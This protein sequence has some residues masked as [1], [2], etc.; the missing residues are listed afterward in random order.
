[1]KHIILF[2]SASLLSTPYLHVHF[3]AT[4]AC[5]APQNT[6]TIRGYDFAGGQPKVVALPGALGEISGLSLTSGGRLFCHND[7]AGTIYEIDYKTGKEIK[8]FSLGMFTL[9]G[10]FEGIAAAKQDTLF[11]VNSSGVLH[12]F[13]EGPAGKSVKYDV[14][15]TSLTVKNDVEGLAYD[16]KTDCLLLACKGD[17]GKGLGKDKAIYAFSLKTYKLDPKPRFVLSVK[18]ILAQTGKKEFNPSAIERHPITG[19]FFVLAYN[20][21]AIAEINPEGKILGV[22]ELKKSLHPQPEGLAIANDGTLI[23][24]NEGQGKTATLVIYS[25]RK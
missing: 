6:G 9:T 7:E 18:D 25:P 14:F 8:H 4:T 16:P 21:L 5:S 24:S 11:L 22:S 1:M 3:L 15:K 12:R 13:R 2:V 17:G 20:G 10:D 23:I 19:N